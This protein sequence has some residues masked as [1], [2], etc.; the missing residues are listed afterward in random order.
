LIKINVTTI[1]VTTLIIDKNK[2]YNNKCYNID[3]CGVGALFISVIASITTNKKTRAC[4]LGAGYFAE[5]P[6]FLFSNL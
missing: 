4:G 3:Y 6:I 2:C 1:N 5:Y